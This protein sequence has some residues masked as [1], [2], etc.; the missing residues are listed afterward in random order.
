LWHILCRPVAHKSKSLFA[1]C[2]GTFCA[3]PQHTRLFVPCCGT[4][5]AFPWHML[6]LPVAHVVPSSGTCCAFQWHMLCLPVAHS[7]MFPLVKN[8]IESQE[9]AK[10][11]GLSRFYRFD[12]DVGSRIMLTICWRDLPPRCRIFDVFCK[13]K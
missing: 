7:I 9:F 2:Y 10:K 5:C 12:D 3:Y 13:T 11:F 8:C 4:F 1:S 6:C